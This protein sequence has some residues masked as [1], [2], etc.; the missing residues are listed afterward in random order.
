MQATASARILRSA[1]LVMLIS[2][3]IAGALAVG[4]WYLLPYDSLD[5]QTA[6]QRFARWEAV[7]W[8]LGATG[9]LFGVAALFNATD[10]HAPRPLEQV[11]QQAGDARRG[12]TLY[13][14]LPAFPWL[15][16]GCGLALI[17]AA[18]AARGALM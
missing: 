4:A 8:G 7:M 15:M 6:V 11:L 5:A 9:T 10:L 13:S 12:R 14:D 16:L 17:L 3:S 1:A 2:A 18:V